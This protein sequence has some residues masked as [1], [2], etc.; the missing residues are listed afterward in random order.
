MEM[1]FHV[2]NTNTSFLGDENNPPAQVMQFVHGQYVIYFGARLC[3]FRA[4]YPQI[5]CFASYYH[6]PLN[7]VCQVFHEKIL[8][9]ADVGSSTAE[10]VALFKEV[11][12]LTPR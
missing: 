6:I 5:F 2:P 3:K 9:M 1:S 7:S 8:S 10:A 4:V 12:I 11:T